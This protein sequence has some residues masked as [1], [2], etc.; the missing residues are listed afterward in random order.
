[1]SFGQGSNGRASH[2]I[3]GNELFLIR[4]A[5]TVKRLLV[6]ALAVGSVLVPAVAVTASPASAAFY[7]ARGTVTCIDPGNVEGV[8][9]SAGTQSGW[10]ALSPAGG[11]GRVASYYK[12]FGAG[13]NY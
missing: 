8:W 6:S 2:S 4:G 13:S 7:S 12:S 11:I 3:K 5:A 9:I 1:M 10:A